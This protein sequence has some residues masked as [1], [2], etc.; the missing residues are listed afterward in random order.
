MILS[1]VI[2]GFL[3]ICA[4]RKYQKLYQ[5]VPLNQACN[6]LLPITLPPSQR[7]L[8]KILNRHLGMHME[9]RQ[10]PYYVGAEVRDGEIAA[11]LQ[12]S[13]DSMRAKEIQV[14]F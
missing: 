13:E 14:R 4:W 11:S 8:N 10:P 1:I 6:G 2:L 12:V 3:L 9:L 5:E 7:A